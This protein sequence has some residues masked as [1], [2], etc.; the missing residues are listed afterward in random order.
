[1]TFGGT[2]I[3]SPSRVNPIPAP[4]GSD[5][6]DLKSPLN[7]LEDRLLFNHSEIATLKQFRNPI[8]LDLI[9]F[10]SFHKKSILTF[11]PKL[12]LGDP[13]MEKSLRMCL[14]ST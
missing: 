13:V 14:S 8:S 5:P 3:S 7:D 2:V 1:M 10:L 12:V 9:H 11:N 4:V 6:L